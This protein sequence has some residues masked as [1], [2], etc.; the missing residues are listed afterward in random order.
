MRRL[1]PPQTGRSVLHTSFDR[2]RTNGV[3]G[4]RTLSSV[5]PELVEG[6]APND[7]AAGFSLIEALVALAILAILLAPAAVRLA[8]R[9]G[10]GKRIATVLCDTGFRYL[11]TLFD[12]DWRRAKGLE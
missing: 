11:S 6:R 8:R 2:L 1:P 4:V 5:R 12:P 10:P 9:L 3:C 7:A